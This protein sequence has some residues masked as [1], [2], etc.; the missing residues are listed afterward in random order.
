MREEGGGKG[1]EDTR[2]LERSFG[3]NV[4]PMDS[5]EMCRTD[6]SVQVMR[7]PRK[8]LLDE[9]PRHRA[10]MI[11]VSEQGYVAPFVPRF[12]ASYRE[13]SAACKQASLIGLAI[14]THK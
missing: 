7:G 6:N 1:L 8:A 5:N 13:T 12:S 9:T 4:F 3:K 2:A 14:S 11:H 10:S